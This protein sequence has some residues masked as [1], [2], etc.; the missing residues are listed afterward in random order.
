LEVTP[1]TDADRD[2]MREILSERWG[3]AV[4]FRCGMSHDASLLPGFVAREG[5]GC[6]GL[7]TYRLEERECEVVTLDALSQWAGIGTALLRAVEEKAA[8]AG[9]RRIWLVTSN[10]NV[11]ALRFYQR[12]GYHIAA[13]RRGAIDGTRTREKPSIPLT[14]CYGIPIRD[15]ILVEKGLPPAS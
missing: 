1:V 12:R 13:V 5:D 2:W 11:D 15:E 6:L 3:G 10:D 9:C 7:V 14:G 4:M 8:E